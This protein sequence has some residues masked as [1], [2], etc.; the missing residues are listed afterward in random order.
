[1]V[2]PAPAAPPTVRLVVKTPSEPI[3]T[4]E[5]D[6][7]ETPRPQLKTRPMG[8]VNASEGAPDPAPAPPPM[9]TPRPEPPSVWTPPQLVPPWMTTIGPPVVGPGAHAHRLLLSDTPIHALQRRI[10]FAYVP[11]GIADLMG[12][13]SSRVR[14]TLLPS[15]SVGRVVH[16]KGLTC[17]VSLL[18][19]RPSPAVQ[20]ERAADIA[21]VT[22][23]AQEIGH[24]RVSTS[25]TQTGQ[26]VFPIGS[27]FIA[28]GLDDCTDPIL[29]DFGPGSDAYLIYTRGRALPPKRR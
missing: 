8:S 9:P 7:L 27:E 3:I 4:V 6:E 20:F 10:H 13:Q 22:P 29:F 19:G 18:G 5:R 21:L 1:V 23:R 14:V 26:S 11:N 15:P 28:V 24:I 17:F 25:S 12:T 2:S 16:I